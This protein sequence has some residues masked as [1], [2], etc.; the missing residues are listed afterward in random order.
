MAG[1]E[2]HVLIGRDRAHQRGETARR[3]TIDALLEHARITDRVE[4]IFDTAIAQPL[5]LANR[6]DRR[7]VDRVGGAEVLRDRE[8]AVA[9]V[10]RDDLPRAGDPRPLDH[11]NPDAACAKYRDG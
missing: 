8:L 11:R 2:F 7:S 4:G 9:N 5:D 1:L 3:K 6:V 10:H